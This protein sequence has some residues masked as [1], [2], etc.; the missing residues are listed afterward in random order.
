MRITLALADGVALDLDEFDGLEQ[1]AP[2][3]ASAV[4]RPADSGRRTDGRMPS[5][6]AARDFAPVSVV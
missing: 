6:Y 4:K 1:L 3:A 5:S 2:A